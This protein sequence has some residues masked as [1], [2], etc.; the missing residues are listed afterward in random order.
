MA[1]Y[2]E[3]IEDEK[4]DMDSFEPLEK[5]ISPRSLS[6]SS[7]KKLKLVLGGIALVALATVGSK[8]IPVSSSNLS[9]EK[10]KK[11]TKSKSVKTSPN[12]ILFT[13]DDFGWNDVGYNSGDISEATPFMK[14]IVKKSIKLTR[15]YTQ[16]SCTPS[17]VTMM[18]GKFAYKNGFQNYE[19]QQSDYVGVPLSNKL[20]PHYMRD[21]GYKTVGFGKWNIGHCSSKYLPSSRGFDH[22]LGYLCPGHGYTDHNC[23][24]ASGYRDMIEDWSVDGVHKWSNGADYLGTY[25]TLIYKE[26]TQKALRRHFSEYGGESAPMFMWLAHHGIHGEYDSDPIPPSE[27][28]TSN[29]KEYLKVLKKRLDDAGSEQE[30]YSQFFKMRMITAS[31]LMS[32]DNSLK[33][34]VET[35]EDVGQLSNSIIFVN[36]DNGAD[37][38]YTQGHPGNNFPLRSEKFSYYEGGVRVP[39]FV[40]GPGHIPIKSEGSTYHGMMHHVDLLTTFYSL[41]GGDYG[42]LDSDVDGMDQWAAIKGDTSSPRTELVLNLPRSKTWKMGEQLTSEGIA[43]RMGNYKLLYNH[44][45]DSWF[46]PSPGDDFTSASDMMAAWCQYSF[47]DLTE[48]SGCVFAN[49]LFNVLDDPTEQTNLW[50]HSDYKDIKANMI[51]R[52]EELVAAQ[53][54]DYG[55]IIPEYYERGL[56]SSASIYE[57]AFEAYGDYV[58]PFACEAIN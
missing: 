13:V 7:R 53:I 44:V 26:E 54:N 48:S 28:L 25:D 22:F 33:N 50:H 10:D 1:E 49:F 35:I 57:D 11:I 27:L 45:Y 5:T 39:A 4:F 12:V 29:N 3:I 8:S 15:Y 19:L 18:T 6:Q 34:L 43:L 47:Y 58:V 2:N 41:G 30:G 20:M 42:D 46:S 31:V 52:A 9:E 40:Y 14:E 38:D 51:K 37:P 36:S 24:T 16:P 23:G 21:L 56:N 55:K 32:L 17:R